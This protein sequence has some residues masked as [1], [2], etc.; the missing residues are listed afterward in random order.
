MKNNLMI[1]G[2]APAWVAAVSLTLATGLSAPAADWPQFMGPNGDGTSPEKGLR[3][4]WPTDGPKVLWTVPMGKGYGGAAVRDGKV[5]VMDRIDQK[6]DVLRCLDLAMGKE[7]W[8]FAYDAPGPID[9]EGPRCTPAVSDQHVFTT[10]P[11]GQFRCIDRGTHQMVWTK[12]LLA[13]YGTKRPNWAVSQSAL[14]YK[15]LVIVAPQAADVGVAAFDQATGKERWRSGSIGP[16]AYASPK[17]VTLEGS[18][19]IVIVNGKGA[20]AVSA[21]AGKV[22]WEY[23]H[24]CKIPVPNVT[25]LG[26]GKLFVTGGYNAGSAIIQVS[27]QG[28]EWTAK[29][30]ARIDQIGGHCHPGLVLAE[31]LYILCNTNERNDGM[32]CFDFNGKL[33]WQSKRDPSLDKGGSLL[34]AD[35]LIYVMDGRTGELHIVEPSPAGFKSLGKA[36]LLDGPEIWGPLALAN[37]KLLLRDQSQMKCVDLKAN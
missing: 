37:G 23:A 5:Y 20:A 25:A 13:D 10:G 9:H 35:G 4:A 18:D 1:I 11:F 6:Q 30:L 26:N 14:L 29:E 31:H 24:P 22:L 34:T 27:R 17:L 2:R 8:T 3:R 16:M 15:D 32:V 28:D 33:V 21:A 7:E 12:H 36:K 19:Q